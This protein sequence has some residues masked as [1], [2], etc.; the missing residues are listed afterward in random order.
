MPI[1]STVRGSFG[2]Q[3][4][5]GKS[6]IGPFTSFGVV[7][8]QTKPTY[9]TSYSGTDPSGPHPTQLT[10]MT[11]KASL[12]PGGLTYTDIVL[13]D[14]FFVCLYSVHG[15]DYYNSVFLHANT[16]K[17][18]THG[19]LG[20]GNTSIDYGY[21]SRY[22]VYITPDGFDVWDGANQSEGAGGNAGIFS[23]ISGQTTSGYIGLR[24]LN[25]K[26]YTYYSNSAPGAAGYANMT[27]IHGPSTSTYTD[28]VRLGLFVHDADDYLE[29][30]SPGTF[31]KRPER[32]GGECDG[33]GVT[34]AA[35]ADASNVTGYT[36][37]GMTIYNLN[38]TSQG[39][40]PRHPLNFDLTTD[41]TQFAFHTGHQFPNWWPMYLAIQVNASTPKVLNQIDWRLHGN[42]V[43]NVDVFGS[44]RSITASNFADESLYTHLGRVKMPGGSSGLSDGNIVTQSFNT[45]GLGYKWYLIKGV[46][47]RNGAVAPYPYCDGSYSSS[48][49]NPGGWAMYGLR[50]NKV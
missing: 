24:R 32:V 11:S 19:Q 10:R 25:G 20:G 17:D 30:Y 13:T 49:T 35:G 39:G 14:D 27:L 6:Q 21:Q 5:F 44:N 28:P 3:G 22:G 41:T 47:A 7:S 38:A 2:A 29:V 1:N 48:T 42:A 15:G 40:A 33:L 45:A 26:F 37:T 8:P 9:Y 16:Y 23:L 46:D 12:R 34:A 36:N 18:F 43:G 50:L 4:R 31:L